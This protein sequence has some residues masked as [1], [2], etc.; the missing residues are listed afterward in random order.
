MMARQKRASPSID[1]M[2]GINATDQNAA[3]NWILMHFCGLKNAKFKVQIFL[4][5]APGMRSRPGAVVLLV[6]GSAIY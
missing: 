6:L 5:S 4:P 2:K 1:L 3:E